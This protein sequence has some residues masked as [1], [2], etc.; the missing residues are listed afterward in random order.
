MDAAQ[1]SGF[2]ARSTPVSAAPD[3]LEPGWS[4]PVIERDDGND[5][6]KVDGLLRSAHA[7]R[8]ALF[9]MGLGFDPRCS[10]GL[11]RYVAATGVIP[12]VVA[13]RLDESTADVPAALDEHQSAN[14]ETVRALAGSRLLERPYPVV[15]EPVGVGRAVAQELAG[16]GLLKGAGQIVVDASAL[17]TTIVLPL[18]KMLLDY[19]VETS[20]SPELQLLV[21][22]NPDLDADITERGVV[23]AAPLPGFHA[24]HLA[25]PRLAGQVRAWAPVLGE[26]AGPA[27]ARVAAFL[28]PDEVYPVLPFPATDPRRADRLFLEHR[29]LLVDQYRVAAGNVLYADERNP[30]DL[31][32]ALVRWHDDTTH[33]LVP[34]G[35]PPL[36]CLSTHSSKLLSVGVLLA[37]YQREMP[38]V[39]TRATGYHLEEGAYGKSRREMDRTAVVWL[40]GDP[41][42]DFPSRPSIEPIR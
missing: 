31:A 24:G 27:L 16:S 29:A 32:A 18:G 39:A 28:E 3:E 34:L 20:R 14:A 42:R 1:S 13:L 30:F 5:G 37:A 19:C 17:P 40:R 2:Q 35:V 33:A 11:E 9:V 36:V 21:V 7:D 41:Y 38:I 12:R 8:E 10:A 26:G 25:K 22:E 4:D 23:G 6:T 15:R